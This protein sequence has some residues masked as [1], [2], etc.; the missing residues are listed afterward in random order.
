VVGTWWA[1]FQFT[2]INIEPTILRK[3]IEEQLVVGA[4]HVVERHWVPIRA[5][6]T[7]SL[8]AKSDFRARRLLTFVSKEPTCG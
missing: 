8:L 5:G 6:G 2:R 7:R 1:H 3:E 4:F